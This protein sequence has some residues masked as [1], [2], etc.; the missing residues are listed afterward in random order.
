MRIGT[1]FYRSAATGRPSA[2]FHLADSGVLSSR[3]SETACPGSRSGGLPTVAGASIM[4][5]AWRG[6]RAAE[7]DGLENRFPG[8]R[9][10][11]SNPTPSATG[12]PMMPSKAVPEG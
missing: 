5:L 4:A 6:G 11:G 9:D 1:E 7:C 10:V 8:D 2:P 12:K 3:Y